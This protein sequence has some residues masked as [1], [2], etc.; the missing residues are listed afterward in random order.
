MKLSPSLQR[1]AILRAI[2]AA[3]LSTKSDIRSEVQKTHSYCSIAHIDKAMADHGITRVRV[4]GA[5]HKFDIPHT[6]HMQLAAI[7]GEPE[8]TAVEK[9]RVDRVWTKPMQGCA[10]A[11]ALARN[12]HRLVYKAK[13]ANCT[14]S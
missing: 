14:N 3:P 5:G 11:D 12:A 4:K 9:S 7:G 2:V 1:T 13:P 8:S 6:V 10:L